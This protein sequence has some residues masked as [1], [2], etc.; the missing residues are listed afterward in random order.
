MLTPLSLGAQRLEQTPELTTTI[1]S[2]VSRAASAK[3]AAALRGG[4]QSRCC[5]FLLRG[6]LL[7][8]AEERQHATARACER[9]RHAQVTVVVVEHLSCCCPLK[10]LPLRSY[11][12]LQQQQNT[13]EKMVIL[14]CTTTVTYTC[15]S[16]QL[17]RALPLNEPLLLRFICTLR[18][19]Y[20]GRGNWLLCSQAPET[21]QSSI[22]NYSTAQ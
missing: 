14:N 22:T 17:Q 12:S 1:P 3:N 9:C 21:G 15:R 11:S 7:R 5:C 19:Q 10:L 18:V 20:S 13:H 6:R 4:G 16:T 2:I 8:E